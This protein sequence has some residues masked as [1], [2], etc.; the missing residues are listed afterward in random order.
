ME[1]LLTEILQQ[2]RNIN[3]EMKILKE[4]VKSIKDQS[5][6][7]R[8]DL[9]LIKDEQGNIKTGLKELSGGN[10]A[11]LSEIRTVDSRIDEIQSDVVY[12]KEGYKQIEKRIE[13]MESLSD[14]LNETMGRFENDERAAGISTEKLMNLVFDNIKG[15]RQSLEEKL[16]ENASDIKNIKENVT[17][18]S[19]DLKAAIQDMERLKQ[20]L[21]SI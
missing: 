2:I 13:R 18:V 8:S 1:N 5:G 6:S 17:S 3:D 4:D 15:L 7:Q 9:R 20:H 21:R 10:A 12:V 11:L 19:N 16:G 14:K